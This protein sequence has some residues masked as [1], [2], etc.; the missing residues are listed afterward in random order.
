MNSGRILV[1]G[2]SFYCGNST[3]NLCQFA[4]KSDIPAAY[5]HPSEKQC[6]YVYTHPTTKQCTWNPDLSNYALKSD[7]ASVK[8]IGFLSAALGTNNTPTIN[9]L[10]FAASFAIVSGFS[11]DEHDEHNL[12]FPALFGII[13]RGDMIYGDGV[14][15]RIE[16][17]SDGKSIS[18]WK[19]P[20]GYYVRG[21]LH[22]VYFS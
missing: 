6:N 19:M 8:K 17:S 21:Y 9:Q 12:D 2:S 5:V 1:N 3:S 15:T 13:T 7:I 18:S 22:A 14:T 16:L 20:S 11:T 4:L 10:D